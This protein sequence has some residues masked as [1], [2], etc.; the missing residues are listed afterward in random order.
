MAQ[1]AYKTTG[2]RGYSRV[3]FFLSGDK[4]YINEINTLPGFTSTSMYPKLLANIG[5]SYRDLI[6]KIIEFA[7][8]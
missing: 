4:F 3:D 2:C 1:K 5:I 6:T 8:E 7:L